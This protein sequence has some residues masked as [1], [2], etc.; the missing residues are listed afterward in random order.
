[1]DFPEMA[2]PKYFLGGLNN[3]GLLFAART[4]AK[5]HLSSDSETHYGVDQR[6]HDRHG[7]CSG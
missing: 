1:M 2:A 6:K 3:S 5:G 7:V 4:P